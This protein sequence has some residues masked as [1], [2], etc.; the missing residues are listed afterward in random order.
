MNITYWWI[1]DAIAAVVLIAFMII[2]SK[3]GL[4]KAV[5]SL[6]G[7]VLSVGI[8]YSVSNAIAGGI[9][10]TA[11]QRANKTNVTSHIYSDTLVNDLSGYLESLDYS[12]SVNPNKLEKVISDAKNYDEAIYKYVNNINGKTVDTPENFSLKLHEGYGYILKNI[13]SKDFTPYCA[14]YAAKTVMD[15]PEDFEALIPLLLDE[16]QQD[17]AAKYIIKHFVDPPY[18]YSFKLIGFIVLLAVLMILSIIIAGATDRNEKMETSF[19]VHFIGGML[20]LVK[21]AMFVVAIALVFRISEIYGTNKD[22]YFENPVISQT[23]A[24]KYVYDFI[25]NIK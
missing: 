11:S 23:Y 22:V 24:F 25:T 14:E 12:L 7:F 3:R 17:E 13:L 4:M 2:T 5:V 6:V 10:E 20:G 21:G 8:S 16:E 15:K 19:A 9:Y 18:I 1:Y